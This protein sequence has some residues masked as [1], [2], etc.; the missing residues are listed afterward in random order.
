MP[1]KLK[2]GYS[3]V[4][5]TED[6]TLIRKETINAVERSILVIPISISAFKNPYEC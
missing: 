5:R 4:L 6:V 2:T 1:S 3:L